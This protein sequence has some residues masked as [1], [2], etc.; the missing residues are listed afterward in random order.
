[1]REKRDDSP[2]NPNGSGG[3]RCRKK[4]KKSINGNFEGLNDIRFSHGTGEGSNSNRKKSGRRSFNRAKN[5]ARKIDSLYNGGDG[6]KITGCLSDIYK[7]SH[8][9]DDDNGVNS[10]I[11]STCNKSENKHVCSISENE[12]KEVGE[13]IGVMWDEVVG[14]G[15]EGKLRWVKSIIKDEQPSVIGLQETKSGIVDEY[16]VEEVWGNRCFGFTQL[17]SNGNSGGIILIWDAITFVCKEAMRDE[18]LA[19]VIDKMGGAWFIFGDFNVIRKVDDRLNSQVKIKDM[20]DFNDSINLSQLV[21]VPMGGRKF[22]RVSDDGVKFS[23]LD[24]FLMNKNFKSLWSNPAVLALY[25]KL[26]DHC[27]MVLKDID[28]DFGPKPFRVFDVW[29]EEVDIEHVVSDTWKK[30]VRGSWPD[31]RRTTMDWE[32]Q[33]EIRNLNDGEMAA[34]ME[35]RKL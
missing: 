4:R 23:K 22:T 2:P 21:E 16:W 35:A 19:G 29:L 3:D 15:A 28:V 17:T 6:G 24:R 31:C 12:M 5:L 1:M 7:V 18:R 13:H 33:A 32:L 27:P 14:I 8:K 26:S 20:D 11:K 10:E 25:R 9:E 30:V 34:W